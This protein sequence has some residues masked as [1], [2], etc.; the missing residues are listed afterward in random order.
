MRSFHQQSV[1]AVLLR[2]Q[3]VIGSIEY[4]I[5][6]IYVLIRQSNF[7]RAYDNLS[8]LGGGLF[9]RWNTIFELGNTI[10]S[11]RKKQAA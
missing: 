5:V 8:L 7:L 9:W 10:F 2:G 3:T 6:R 4:R 1:H 11:S